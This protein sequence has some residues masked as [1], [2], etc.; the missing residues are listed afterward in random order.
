MSHIWPHKEEWHVVLGSE[1][2][3]GNEKLIRQCLACHIVKET[4]IPPIMTHAWHE[5]ITASG[6]RW[7]GEATP[8]CIPRGE[9]IDVKFRPSTIVL[10]C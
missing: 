4:V 5:W 8:P 9:P 6:A 3:D 10:A 7:I 1:C 2:P